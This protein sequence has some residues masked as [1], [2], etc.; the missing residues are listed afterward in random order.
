MGQY[1]KLQ[2]RADPFLEF[3]PK[4]GLAG[5]PHQH[6]RDEAGQQTG[7]GPKSPA[8]IRAVEMPLG[9]FDLLLEHADGLVLG[10]R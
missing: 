6:A 5:R 1:L 7:H 4:N 3:N 9:F 2:P 10:L 8:S